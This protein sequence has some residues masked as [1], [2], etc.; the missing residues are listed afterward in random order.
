M[1]FIRRAAQ[2]QLQ[3]RKTQLETPNKFWVRNTFTS[4]YYFFRNSLSLFL[5]MCACACVCVC[6]RSCACACVCVFCLGAHI[7]SSGPAAE[8]RKRGGG[9]G[10][11]GEHRWQPAVGL[12]CHP[13]GL[14]GE[15]QRRRSDAP[16]AS[17]AF[18]VRGGTV[19]FGSW[20]I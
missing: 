20:W 14:G 6:V 13:R 9:G 18:C 17:K 7:G 12:A 19:S 15:W 8:E 11:G 16:D 5:C 3:A 4:I 10:G 2:P 1:E